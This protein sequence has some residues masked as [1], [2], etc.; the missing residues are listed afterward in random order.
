MEYASKLHSGLFSALVAAQGAQVDI[1]HHQGEVDKRRGGIAEMVFQAAK[2]I[3]THGEEAVTA[4]N[5]AMEKVSTDWK[6]ESG[7]TAVP[8]AFTQACSNVRASMKA[9]LKPADYSSEGAMREAKKA[10]N[11]AKRQAEKSA[12]SKKPG[13]IDASNASQIVGYQIPAAVVDVVLE[14]AETLALAADVCGD[15]TLAK[16][17]AAKKG[18]LPSLTA[19]LAAAVK[20]QQGKNAELIRNRQAV[21]VDQ[22][23]AAQA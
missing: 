19:K 6:A 2:D 11:K 13:L 14:F 20:H 4:F 15:G 8:R 16:L 18:G 21:V 10:A 9:G 23:Q 12:E 22:G 17:V 5:A 7:Q 3:K 1:D